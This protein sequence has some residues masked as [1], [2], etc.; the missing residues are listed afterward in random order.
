MQIT[1]SIYMYLVY[2]SFI[3]PKC[4]ALSTILNR[5][6]S[7][8]SNIIPNFLKIASCISPL[9]MLLAIDCT[10]ITFI[11][12]STFPLVLFFSMSFILDTV[13][14]CFYFCV[15]LDD[16]IFSLIPFI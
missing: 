10:C 5:R 15:Y 14:S 12:L 2:L 3:F 16:V 9:K 13:S 4:G 11:V 6:D 7:E 1:F 8:Q